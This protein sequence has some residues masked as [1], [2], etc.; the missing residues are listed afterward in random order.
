LSIEPKVRLV[1]GSDTHTAAPFADFLAHLEDRPEAGRP[2]SLVAAVEALLLPTSE[3][4]RICGVS[5]A[6]WHRLK[7]AAMTP[8]P[9]RLG[10]KV[11]YRLSDLRLWTAW[12]CP[13]R[14][15]FDAR[16]NGNGQPRC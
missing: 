16:K 15:E 4:A 2:A 1:P 12:G 13:P 11:L 9:V 7:A 14:K 3:A 8:A 5:E 10:G 6:S